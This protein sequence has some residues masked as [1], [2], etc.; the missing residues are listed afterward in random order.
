MYREIFGELLKQ[1][2]TIKAINGHN[3]ITGGPAEC[4]NLMAHDF[5]HFG[6]AAGFGLASYAKWLT[7]HDLAQAYRYHHLLLKLLQWKWPN[8]HWVLK[9]PMHLFGLDHLLKEYPDAR[10]VFTHRNPASAT[11]SGASLF[12]HWSLL[13]LE[14]PKPETLGTWWPA[15]W[16]S[17][18][19]RAI[20]VRDSQPKLAVCDVHHNDITNDPIDVVSRIYQFFGLEVSSGHLR[21]MQVWL[22]ENPRKRYGE[23]AYHPSQFGMRAEE[24]VEMFKSYIDRFGIEFGTL[25]QPLI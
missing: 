16:N 24:V 2:P 6:F 22:R 3:A 14:N 10:I 15:L 11:A 13:A 23:H 5:S 25:N 1:H 19:Q 8:E 17:V 9:A 18:L 20:A 21:R 4:Q 7:S 12:H